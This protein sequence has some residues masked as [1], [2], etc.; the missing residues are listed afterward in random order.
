MHHNYSYSLER[1]EKI[2]NK[3]DFELQCYTGLKYYGEHDK[4]VE[5]LV[6]T[7]E[8]GDTGD[9]LAFFKLFR[10]K[11]LVNAKW[12]WKRNIQFIGVI[13]KDP[14]YHAHILIKKPH[15]DLPILLRYWQTVYKEGSHITSRFLYKD[16]TNKSHMKTIVTYVMNNPEEHQSSEYFYF[17]SKNWGVK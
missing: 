12:G 5:H 2:E 1:V 11:I 7:M 9:L 4:P 17:K 8:T 13:M 15:V 3:R 14:H 16:K 6:L 10:H